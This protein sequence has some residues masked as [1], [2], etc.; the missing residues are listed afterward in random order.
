[1]FSGFAHGCCFHRR[2]FFPFLRY[3]CVLL[4]WRFRRGHYL[5]EAAFTF[6]SLH[7]SDGSFPFYPFAFPFPLSFLT[8]F[9]YNPF[10]SFPVLSCP[11]LS[12][13]VLFRPFPS[14]PFFPFLFLSLSVF[15]L[16]SPFPFPLFP[17]F[18]PF[19]FFWHSPLGAG[20]GGALLPYRYVPLLGATC[21]HYTPTRAE[22]CCFPS[23][24][25]YIA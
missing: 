15:F 14:F 16:S 11:F 13:P 8:I 20:P 4:A 21:L 23:R 6:Y 7:C 19:L 3:R 24:P 9:P 1:M 5:S 12:F 22:V 10:L 2:D 18:F 17:F 25:L